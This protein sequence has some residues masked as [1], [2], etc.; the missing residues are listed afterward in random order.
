MLGHAGLGVRRVRPGGPGCHLEC[1]AGMCGPVT[2]WAVAGSGPRSFRGW[3]DPGVRAWGCSRVRAG[4]LGDWWVLPRWVPRDR[5]GPLFPDTPAPGRAGGFGVTAGGQGPVAMALPG[6]R[7]PGW[8]VLGWGWT[9][10]QPW[11]G[12][13]SGYQAV[14]KESG[15]PS[16]LPPLPHL[17]ATVPLVS[18]S[19]GSVSSWGSLGVSG[20][21]LRVALGTPWRGGG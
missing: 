13:N 8:D 15:S 12:T 10:A 21:A 17:G 7:C 9:G 14:P 11:P 6:T 2:M 16:P 19:Q 5:P 4:R 1:V 20:A 3:W 18:P